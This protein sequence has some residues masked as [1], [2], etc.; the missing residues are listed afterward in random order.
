MVV[1]PV[2]K[3]LPGGYRIEIAEVDDFDREDTGL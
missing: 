2:P 1:T 3:S